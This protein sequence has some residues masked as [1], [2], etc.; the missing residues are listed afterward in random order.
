LLSGQVTP[1]IH[2]HFSIF[3]LKF[4]QNCGPKHKSVILPYNNTYSKTKLIQKPERLVYIIQICNPINTQQKT[5]SINP[6]T[7]NH[8]KKI[9]CLMLLAITLIAGCQPKTGTV[10]LAADKIAVATQ[11]D[12]FHN[13]FK[14]KDITTYAS[15][16]D[17]AGLYCGTDS[18]ELLTKEEFLK[19]YRQILS[20]TAVKIA[21][22]ID[23]R[24]IRVAKDGNSAITLE[25]F[26]FSLFTPRIPWRAV[27]HFSKIGE[28]WKIDFVSWSLIPNN[29]DI[30][31]LNKALL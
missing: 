27:T 1:I 6:K 28:D 10:D 9:S 4:H 23:K 13:A 11:L 25:Q 14:G 2:L 18:K 16:L 7:G 12:K 3:L 15:L 30:E 19:S 21:Y 22:T 24:E 17:D 29:E 5:N 31:K 26:L 8:M 20:D